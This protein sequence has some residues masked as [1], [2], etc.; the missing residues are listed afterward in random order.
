M[1][2]ESL[3]IVERQILANQFKILS[4]LSEEDSYESKD[5]EKKAEI[6]E[7]GYTGEYSEVFNVHSEE[8]SAEI[9]YETNEIL[10][11]Y[12]RIN[13]AIAT[14]TEDEKINLD[15]EK[16]K[17]EGFDANNDSHYYYAKYM[18]ENLDKW[19][20]HKEMHLNSHSQFPLIKYKKMLSIQEEA[21]QENKYDLNFNDLQKM[22]N[23]I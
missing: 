8:V 7:N 18:I 2:P 16:I 6:I 12:R 14:L 22:I 15:L 4:K 13:N 10:N 21:F 17:F 23:S 11:M 3:T 5:Y 19:Q 9:C 20:E 1:K